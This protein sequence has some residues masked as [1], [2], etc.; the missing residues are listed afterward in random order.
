MSTIRLGETTFQYSLERNK[1]RTRLAIQLTAPFTL[2]LKVPYY[3]TQAQIRSLLLKQSNWILR[4]QQ[5]F[6]TKNANPQL[7]FWGQQHR[8][9]IRKQQAMAKPA[10]QLT[11]EQEILLTLPATH[12]SPDAATLLRAWYQKAATAKLIELTAVWAPRLGVKPQ[13]I[14]I[15][16][17]RT[18]WGS[19]SSLGNINYNWRIMMAP[20]PVIEYLVIHELCH[21]RHMNH[22]TD[23]WQMVTQ[24]SPRQ[25]EHRQWLRQHGQACMQPL[26]NPP[27]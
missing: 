13:R 3:A 12:R 6:Q 24:F 11:T 18:R 4:Q 25:L 26:P 5:V 9:V 17:Q 20:L 15:K 7:L 19:C 8:L 14:K 10:I 21:L 22:S 2:L 27:L 23:F 16:E 1:N